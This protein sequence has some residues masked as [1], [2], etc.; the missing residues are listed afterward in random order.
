ML[1]SAVVQQNNK[2]KELQQRGV[3]CLSTLQVSENANSFANLH[4]IGIL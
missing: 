4:P 3:K 2:D 1:P